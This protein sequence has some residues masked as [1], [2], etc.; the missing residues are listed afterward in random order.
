MWWL[1]GSNQIHIQQRMLTVD[2]VGARAYYTLSTKVLLLKFTLMKQLTS[3]K[4][5]SSADYTFDAVP[6]VPRARCKHN[7][8]WTGL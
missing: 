4:A 3:V 6:D 2:L 7:R 8:S 1:H 5:S